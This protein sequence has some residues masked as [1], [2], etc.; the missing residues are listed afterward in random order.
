MNTQELLDLANK[1]NVTAMFNLG[2]IYSKGD[3]EKQTFSKNLV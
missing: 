2:V 3:G 1:G